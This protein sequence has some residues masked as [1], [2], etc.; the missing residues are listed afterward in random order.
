MA[1]HGIPRNLADIA[2]RTVVTAAEAL[3]AV[4]LTKGSINLSAAEVA[5]LGA[6]AGGLAA[7]RTLV[8]NRLSSQRG[9][10][11]WVE[12][13]FSRTIFTFAQTLVAALSVSAIPNGLHLH[14]IQAAALAGVAAALAAVKA[15]LA[16]G[17]LSDPVFSPASLVPA[18]AAKAAGG[19]AAL[20]A[21]RTPTPVLIG[22]G[23][24]G[25]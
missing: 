19:P 7:V 20:A 1:A 10:Q 22:Q 17:V 14:E 24:N 16:R 2:E 4:L 6:I 11:E 13:L 9:P 23:A 5:I 12:D 25:G 8:A 21:A 15:A 18:T 3:G